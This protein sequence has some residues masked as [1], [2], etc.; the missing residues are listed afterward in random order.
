[1]KILKLEAENIKKLTVVEIT[2]NGNLVEIT[3]RNGSGKTSVLDSIA[4]A[5]QGTSGVQSKPIRK[6]AK[7]ARV[8]L[9]LGDLVVTRKFSESGSTL[10]VENKEGASYK[11]PQAI[12]DK[13]LGSI[14]FDPLGFARQRPREQFETLRSL[15]KVDVDFDEID[16]ANDRDFRERADLNKLAKTKRAQLASWTS[17]AADLPAEKIDTGALVDE[18][19]A[20]GKHN[21]DI[22]AE[23]LRRQTRGKEIGAIGKRAAVRRRDAAEMRRQAD[24]LDALAAEDDKE[25]FEAAKKLE[26]LP[27]IADPIDPAT[28][29]AKLTDAN[30]L[31]KEIER[32]ARHAELTA[33]AEK[34]EA[35][36]GA[37]TL[38]MSEREAR[39]RDAIAAAQMPIDGIGF[40]DGLVLLN[41]VPFDQASD[42]EQLRAS[43]AIAMA[44][45]PKLRVLRIR[46][47]SLLDE[48][49]LKLLAD[50]AEAQDYQ[51]WI[52]RVDSSGKVGVVMEDGHCAAAKEEPVM[53]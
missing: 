38:C 13:L 42:A 21:A 29:K 7:S 51:L 17:F 41:D 35:E 43:C 40:G 24:V 49:G 25:Y 18:I 27:A 2:P 19:A 3:G 45:N 23:R 39:K 22:I 30:N 44:A 37:L 15:V 47:G 11:T 12:L 46:D 4:W 52:E 20:A 32:K 8:R 6:G 28:V 5:L 48:N 34:I 31:N 9:D 33:E 26:A 10:T 16:R 36:A 50:M 14:A 1:M 53:A